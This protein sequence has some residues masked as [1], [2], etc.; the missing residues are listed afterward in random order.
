MIEQYLNNLIDT[1]STGWILIGFFL[2]SIV[3]HL[4]IHFILVL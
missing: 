4:V 1:Y 3:G 2:A